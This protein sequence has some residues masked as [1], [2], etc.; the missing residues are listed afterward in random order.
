MLYNIPIPINEKSL[1]ALLSTQTTK[2]LLA[3][4]HYFNRIEFWAVCS[5]VIVWT[6][7][8]RVAVK[9]LRFVRFELPPNI[10]VS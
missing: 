8:A 6:W 5:S 10:E 7:I 1:L 3:A 4:Q 9:T 2:L